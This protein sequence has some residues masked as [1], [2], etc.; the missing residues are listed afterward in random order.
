VPDPGKTIAD[1]PVLPWNSGG[2]DARVR[3][4]VP[5]TRSPGVRLSV[6]YD[7]AVAAVDHSHRGDNDRTPRLVQ[8]LVITRTCS[9]R[10]GHPAAARGAEF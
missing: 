9:V 4:D 8:R 2:V 5:T 7:S 1:G 3:L 6:N 10:L